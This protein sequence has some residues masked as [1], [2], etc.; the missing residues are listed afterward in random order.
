MDPKNV[1]L[2]GHGFHNQVGIFK[3]LENQAA[4]QGIEPEALIMEILNDWWVK[5]VTPKSSDKA[6]S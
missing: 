1:N 2:T 6:N 3:G 5:K 4:R